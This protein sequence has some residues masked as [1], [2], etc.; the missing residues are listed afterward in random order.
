MAP[1]RPRRSAL[2][3]PRARLG[4]GVL[5]RGVTSRL[6]GRASSARLRPARRARGK[7]LLDR[8]LGTRLRSPAAFA[9]RLPTLGRLASVAAVGPAAPRGA[10]P[11]IARSSFDVP[12]R[13]QLLDLG[14]QLGQRLEHRLVALAQLD[15][16]LREPLDDAVAEEHLD[17]IDGQLDDRAVHPV[18]PLPPDLAEPGPA[19]SSGASP[20]TRQDHVPGRLS[21]HA[22]RGGTVR[23]PLE[24]RPAVGGAA[25]VL[26][27][28]ALEGDHRARRRRRSG[29]APRTRRRERAVRRVDVAVLV[30]HRLAG[31]R[32]SARRARPPRAAGPRRRRLAHAVLQLDLDRLLVA[33]PSPSRAR[34]HGAG[35]DPVGGDVG[36][37]TADERRPP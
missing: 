29:A 32:A 7:L 17:V 4:A 23:R 28:E 34:I 10:P 11:R 26:A 15:L 12:A 24:L 20:A 30:D 8:G 14:Q 25:V 27:R 18:Q 6:V 33:S 31:P 35:H 21:G 37:A 5:G 2:A 3:A 36:S 1:R 22:A 16:E 19:R 13:H 9:R